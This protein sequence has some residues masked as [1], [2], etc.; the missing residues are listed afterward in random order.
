LARGPG[1]AVPIWAVPC[2]AARLLI[3]SPG[4]DFQEQIEKV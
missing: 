4:K 2:R 3:Y 1:R